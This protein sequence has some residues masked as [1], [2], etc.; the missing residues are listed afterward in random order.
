M[1]FSQRLNNPM[2]WL[3]FFRFC[4]IF[5][6]AYFVV[7]GLIRGRRPGR[8][9][10]LVF[11]ETFVVVAC[12]QQLGVLLL[13]QARL[14]LPGALFLLYAAT[15]LAFAVERWKRNSNRRTLADQFCDL[16]AATSSQPSRRWRTTLR[17]RPA[18]MPNAAIVL[19]VLLAAGWFGIHNVS[20]PDVASYTRALSLSVLAN[21]GPWRPDAS[22]AWLLTPGMFSALPAVVAIGASTGVGAAMMAAAAGFVSFEFFRS[23]LCSALATGITG[24]ALVLMPQLDSA[25]LMGSALLLFGAGLALRSRP[26]ALLAAANAMALST[27]T[28]VWQYLAVGTSAVLLAGALALGASG[29]SIRVRGF[30]VWVASV[31]CVAWIGAMTDRDSRIASHQFEAA[32]RACQTIASTYSRNSWL[33]VSPAQEL[34][35]TYGS[36]WHV[37]LGTFV[38]QHTAEQTKNPAFRFQY[39]VAD[40]FFFIEKRPLRPEDRTPAAESVALASEN[41]DYTRIERASLEFEASDILAAYA[42]THSDLRQIYADESIAIYHANGSLGR[43]ASAPSAVN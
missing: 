12:I 16:I 39:P 18:Q 9:W 4:S 1:H 29:W 15:L 40:V 24:L 28:A 25:A 26:V 38:A 27:G 34:A 11:T 6:L 2:G 42:S 43:A 7:P 36:G 5:L 31:F 8:R 3:A 17:C 33:I 19:S 10:G 37:E 32:A 21:G 30:A 14:A 20:L 22:V 23:R 41:A 35:C 13:G